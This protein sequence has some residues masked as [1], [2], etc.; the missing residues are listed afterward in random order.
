MRNHQVAESYTEEEIRA[1]A[2]LVRFPG[3]RVLRSWSDSTREI[4]A[5]RKSVAAK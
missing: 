2:R 3:M 5:K 4:G 1:L